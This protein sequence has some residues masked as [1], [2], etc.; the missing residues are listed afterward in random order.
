MRLTRRRKYAIVNAD[1]FGFSQVISAGILRAHAEGIVTSTTVTANMPAAEAAIATLAGAAGLGV[2]VHLNLSQGPPL[3]RAGQRLAGPDGDMNSSGAGLILKCILVPHLLDAV[4]DECDAQI[5]WVLDHGIRPTHL[6]SHRHAHAFP[7]V[8]SRVAALAR[9][10]HVRFVRW[11]GER[12]RGA[13]WP[14]APVGQRVVSCV[15]NG[16]AAA[17]AARD[18]TLRGTVGT[19]G[20]AHTGRIG[21][22]WL[23]RAAGAIGPG[24]TE[25]MTHPGL[26]D[27][28]AAGQTRLVE[29]RQAELAA[30]CDPTVRQA[31]ARR[32]ITLIHYGQL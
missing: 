29:S 31:F 11:H 8:F 18:C 22:D 21:R 9:R 16:L 20:V 1:D 23:L 24:V 7:P 27:H 32:G 26:A 28:A 25:I 6:D 3:S 19:L 2:G 15:L 12:L 4:Q 14:A 30:L 10:Y 17:N 5:R 13:A